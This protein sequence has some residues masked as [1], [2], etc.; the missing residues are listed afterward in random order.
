[1]NVPISS[2]SLMNG[3][4]TFD[5]D[6]FAVLLVLVDEVFNSEVVDISTLDIIWAVE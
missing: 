4:G 3:I 5:N 1:M 2:A 6:W